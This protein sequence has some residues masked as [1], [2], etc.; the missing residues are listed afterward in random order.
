MTLPDYEQFK[1]ANA[2]FPLVSPGTN[3]LLQDADPALFFALAFF[4]WVIGNDIGAR[5]VAASTTAGAPITAAVLQ[6]YPTPL[7]PYKLENQFQFP[8]L[9]V[10]RTK[11]E[12][13]KHSSSYYT[14][15]CSFDLIYVLPPLTQG[16]AEQILPI[17]RAVEITIRDRCVTSFDPD[18]TPPGGTEGDSPWAPMYA[19]LQAIGFVSGEYGTLTNNGEQFFPCLK[20]SGVFE[21]R[22][23]YVP[24]SR[25]FAGADVNQTL[26]APDGTSISDLVEVSTQQAPDITSLDVSHGIYS[27]GTSVT[28]T[29]TLFLAPLTVLFGG[30][31]AVDVIAVSATEITCVTPAMSGTGVVDITITNFDGQTA[32]FA[33]AFT[34]T[35]S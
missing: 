22:L 18:Y 28:I 15:R 19:Y 26:V 11:T 35:S 27:G 17:L 14:D 23:N 30:N 21:E 3:S 2:A 34:F 33:D 12:Y 13:T 1:T 25:V 29:G 7:D 9:C 5:L 16:Q 4:E 24:L 31:A 10:H 32:T 20:M 6:A 8:L